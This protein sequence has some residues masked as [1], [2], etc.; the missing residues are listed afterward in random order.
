MNRSRFGIQSFD[1]KFRRLF[2][3]TATFDQSARAIEIAG[4]HF[5]SRGIDMIYGMHGQSLTEFARDIQSLIDTGTE[6][7]DCYPITN[8]ATQASLHAGY[9]RLGL[10][11]T[12]YI[13]KLAMTLFLNQYMAAAGFKRHNGHGFIRLGPRPVNPSGTTSVFRN[14][15][16]TTAMFAHHDADV[17]GFGS[18]AISQVGRHV[19]Q[20]DPNRE[21]YA[22]ALNEGK[23]LSV[24]V[25]KNRRIPWDR[26]LVL[27]LPYVGAIDKDRVPWDHIEPDTR[28]K[29]AI[30]QEEGLLEETPASTAPP[31]SAGPGT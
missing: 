1:P 5:A 29:L 18:S 26:G 6:T 16:N 13:D 8:L 24:K 12:P 10:K 4:R 3:I 11:P 14:Y 17:I 22:R 31:S 20:N 28:E 9:A 30:L 23:E 19:L 15:Y 25:T 7:I 2:N 27:Y 21:S